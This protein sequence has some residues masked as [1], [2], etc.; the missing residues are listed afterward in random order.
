MHRSWNVYVCLGF[1]LVLLVSCQAQQPA[2]EAEHEQ[3][4]SITKWT[5]HTELFVE[6]TPFT[7][8]KET[9]LAVHLTNLGG[10]Q[11]VSTEVLTTALESAERQ[12]VTVRTEAPT[13]PGI[14]RPVLKPEQ[15][16]AYRLVFRRFHPE[17]Q[18]LLDTIEAG[19]VVVTTAEE[20]SAPTEAGAEEQGIA[21][22]KEQ[23]WRIAFA[24]EEV[25]PRELLATLTLHAEVKPATGGEAHI[26]APVGGRVLA[27]GKGAPVLGHTVEPGEP[28]AL[29]VPLHP[30][31]TNRTELESGIKTAH[32]ELAAA[33]Q[34]LTR[35]QDLYQ[36]RI[37]PKRRVEQ[38]QKDVAVLQA[39]L[40]A[41]RSQL[42]LLDTSQVLDGKA[43]SPSL[44]R[45][46]LRAPIAGTVV[47]VQMT[48]GA[49]IEAGY[50]LLTLVDLEQVWIEGRMFEPDIPKVRTVEQARFTTPALS[51]PMALA[52]PHARLVTVGSVID[53]TTRSVPLIIEVRN[54]D[55]RLKIGMRGELT[56]PT[57]E[58][59]RDLAIPLSAL[60]DEKGIPI[61]FVQAAGETFARRELTLGVQSDGYVQVKAGLT[62]GERV[63]TTGAYRVYLASLATELPAHGHAH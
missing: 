9:P 40:A 13:V 11:P 16:G 17:T 24:T 19:D 21:F 5:T 32:A 57:G 6:F 54:A 53:P 18:E 60:V 59:V 22:L 27:P 42:A 34:E 44:E 2:T 38:T 55:A 46:I 41:T 56:V 10:F 29:V 45:F 8:G 28:L 1:L 3:S 51:E 36:D 31:G 49:L 50:D 52:T 26:T 4:V 63:V 61:A 39:R 35:V 43:L 30:S 20:N 58:R 7:V 15:P 14:Y 37:V 25:T 23:Q 62:E 12:G 48:P 47:A 33:E